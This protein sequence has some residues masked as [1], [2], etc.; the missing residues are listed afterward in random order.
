MTRECT[1]A[2]AGHA[3]AVT[4]GFRKLGRVFVALFSQV[5]EARQ[6]LDGILGGCPVASDAILCISELAQMPAFIRP[7]ASQ[8]A[9][10]R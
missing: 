10:S 9:S 3:V 7:A 4:T 5:S 6:F 8:A 2:P 1:G